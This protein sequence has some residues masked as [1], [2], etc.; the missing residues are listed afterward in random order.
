M[1]ALVLT[2]SLGLAFAGLFAGGV[3]A[4]ETEDIINQASLEEYHSYLRVLTGVDP[5]PGTDPPVYLTNRYSLYDEIHVAAQWIY[6]HF[7]ALGLDTSFHE[8]DPAYGPNVIGELYGS[9]RPD[10]IYIICG[11]FDTYH[12]ADQHNAPGCD[13]NGSG[14]CTAMMAARILSQYEFEGTIRFIAWAGEEQW[15]VG[16]LAYVADAWD[17]G[18]NIVAAINLDMILH[19]GFDN[20]DPDP[21][22]D[23]DIE[24]NNPSQWLAQYLAEQ[25]AA[26]TPIDFEVHNNEN[27]VSDHW[28]FWQYGYDAVGL[29]ENTTYEIWGGS[30]DDYHQTTDT[31]DNPGYDWDFALHTIRGGMAGLINLAGLIPPECPGDVDGDGDTDQSD[32]G[33][34]LADWG[35]DDPVNGCAGDLDGDDK[36]D[37]V[38]LGI[39]LADWGCGT[40]P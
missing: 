16:S 8:F 24:G 23:I 22:Y 11:H 32:L 18:E 39:L 9:T 12:A 20:H 28:S 40:G 10:D 5:V 21:D 15:M 26:Y 6:D 2:A 7:A 19:P 36:T 4:D 27:Y 34:L 33:I 29:C 14:T 3:A 1:R 25:Y 38:D 30:N 17:A 35:C 37:Q 13:D 31:I